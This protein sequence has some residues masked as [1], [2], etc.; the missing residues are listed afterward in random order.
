MPGISGSGTSTSGL[1][2]P[3]LSSS[4]SSAP[5]SSKSGHFSFDPSK[6]G[7]SI[8]DI[9]VLNEFSHCHPHRLRIANFFHHNF[10]PEP[11]QSFTYATLILAS[12]LFS[13]YSSLKN[14]FICLQYF[15]KQSK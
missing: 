3:G 9:K 12:V 1:T 5:F 4:V 10:H 11:V 6:V 13:F 14:T 2:A 8:F 15:Y 7:P